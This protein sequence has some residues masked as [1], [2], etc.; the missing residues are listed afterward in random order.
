MTFLPREHVTIS[1]HVFTLRAEIAL[2]MQALLPGKAET[3]K[4]RAWGFKGEVCNVEC[5]NVSRPV[6]N[7]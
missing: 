2:H 7:I 5:C 4:Y 1:R 6:I 3:H